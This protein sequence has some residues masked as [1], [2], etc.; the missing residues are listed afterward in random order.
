MLALIGVGVVPGPACAAKNPPP[1]ILLIVMDDIGIDQWKLFGYGGT[2]PAAMPNIAAI[3]K[4]GIRFQNLWAMPACSNGRAALF[5]GRYPFRTHVY[6]AIGNDDLANF[7]V[8]PNEVTVPRLLKQRGYKSALF[9]KFHIGIQSNNPYGYGM[10]QALGWDYFDG[11]LDATGDPSSIDQTAGGV[12]PADTW[13]CGFVRDANHGGA[14]TGAC[15]AGNNTCAVMTKSGTEAP[16]RVCR[17]S[18]GIFDPNQPCANPVPGYINFG[19]LSGHYVSPL[20][21]N[22]EDG[23]IVQVPSTDLR[24]RTYRGTEVVDA[25]I[26]WIN[27]QP[28]DQPWMASMAFATAH[29]PVMQ[30]PSQLLSPSETDT[31]NL[32]C[33]D[34]IDQRV[35][36]NQMEEAL[37]MEVERLMV[38]TGLASRGQNGQLIYNPKKNRT[39][40]IFVTDNGSLGSVVKAPFDGSRSKST[41][42]QTGVWCPGIVAGPAVKSPGR[43]VLAMVNIAD[44][45]E[46]IGELAG[47]DV[48]QS[49]SQTVD[50]QSMLPYL[51]NPTQPSIRKTN[52]T[53][54]GTNLHANSEINGP[55]QYN[56][57]TCTQIAPTKSVCEDNNGIWWGAGATDPST[58]GIPGDGL[59]LCCDVAVWQANHA[60]TISTDIYPL[61]AFGIRND[62]YKL[63]VNGYQA[64]DATSNSCVAKTTTEFYIINENVPLP[65]LDTADADLLATEKSLNREQQKNYD[66]LRAQLTKLLA[67]QPACP[68][69]INLDGIVNYLDVAQ[70][71]M[72][73]ELSMGNSSWA[74][75]NLDGL[76][77]SVDLA[78]ILQNFGACP[79]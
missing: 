13:S 21:I 66:A 34:L 52:Y 33:S 48:H 72:F 58:A 63:V 12:S 38:A 59:K 40:V 26:A 19:T 53:E 7:M 74:D 8:N 68:G 28:K 30:P 16:G 41:V 32:N 55:C 35:L 75:L 20:V 22:N 11:W 54:I 3:A 1:N 50:A 39:Y 9:G 43:K 45:Y 71:T 10:V 65:K 56:T 4:A 73:Q 47:I 77:N 36:T 79:T 25:A 61:E 37:D 24:A 57:T 49:V 31:S 78:I 60:Q 62:R 15:Y 67:S 17:D 6:T 5:T 76:T 27:Q 23:S 51:V 64:Y 69:D 14:D 46:L 70:W 44:L 42:Y 29:T 18:G 2:T